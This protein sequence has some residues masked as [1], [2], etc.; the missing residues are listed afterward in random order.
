MTEKHLAQVEAGAVAS[1]IHQETAKL[2]KAG[3][4]LLAIEDKIQ[5]LIEQANMQPAFKGYLGY[6]AVSCLCVNEEVVHGIPRNYEL[7]EGDILTI[8]FGIRHKGYCVDTARTYPIGKV[9]QEILSFLQTAKSALSSAISAVKVDSPVGIISSTVQK[10][11]EEG[12][13][14]VISDLQGHGVG[15]D[16]QESPAV[17]NVGKP[18]GGELVKVGMSLAI[19]P[20]FSLKYAKIGVLADGW[21]IIT[22]NGTLAV[23]EEDTVLITENGVINATR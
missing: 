11:V 21:T 17:P 4:N 6:P 8:D 22:T 12:G 15:R 3:V 18:T 1:K 7:I 9:N 2:A 19:E 23:Q 14:S 10:I 20:I 16:L 13:Y 5:Q